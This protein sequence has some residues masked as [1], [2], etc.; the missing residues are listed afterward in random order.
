MEI[1]IKGRERYISASSL[2]V[3]A[4]SATASLGTWDVNGPLYQPRMIH[5]RNEASAGMRIGR[6]NQNN[7]RKPTSVPFC[8]PQIPT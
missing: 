1:H 7:Q 4:W 2:S 3:M 6:G 8:P 5:E